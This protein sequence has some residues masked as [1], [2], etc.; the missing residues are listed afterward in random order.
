MTGELL[1]QL[2]EIAAERYRDGWRVPGTNQFHDN[3]GESVK[4]YNDNDSRTVSEALEVAAMLWAI[5]C[6]EEGK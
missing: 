1:H 3:R 2:A 6:A 4:L 5:E